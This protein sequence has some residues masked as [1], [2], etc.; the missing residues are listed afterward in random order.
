MTEK[1]GRRLFTSG[2]AALI[3]LGFVHSLSLFTELAS[4]DETERQL[5]A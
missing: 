5:L 2:G 3:L 4:V 1:W